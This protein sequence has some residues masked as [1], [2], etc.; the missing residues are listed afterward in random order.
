[1]KSRF[2]S[3]AFWIWLLAA[4]FFFAEYMARVSP[5]VMVPDLMQAF[6]VNALKLGILSSFFYYSYVGM[7]LPVGT[8]IDR[9][10]AHKLVTVMAAL[11]GISCFMFAYSSSI[12][13]AA[14]TR[15]IMGFAAAFAFV[16]A[17]SLARTW[18]KPS[19]F[20]LLAGTTQALGM[21]GAA[22]GEAPV[23]L[24]VS[25]LGYRFALMAIGVGLMVL[26]VLMGIIVRDRPDNA[27][28]VNVDIQEQPKQSLWK[29]LKVV[30]STKQC[31]LN[32]LFVG[33]LYAPTAAFA[34]LWGASYLHTVYVVPEAIAAGMSGVIFIGFAVSSPFAGWISDR[35]KRRKPVLFA[36][37][38]LSFIFLSIVLYLPHLSSWFAAVLLFCYGASN[39]AVATSY[40]VA[41]EFVP[42]NVAAT[43]MSFANMT[44]VIIG[45]LFQP[46]IGKL[47][48]LGWN[49]ITVKGVQVYSVHDYRVAMLS[50]PLC[51]V[52]SIITC[53][54]IKESY[55]YKVV[56]N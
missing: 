29:N 22:L 20:G 54:F 12:Y 32:G 56:E 4:V 23:S 41:S 10:G 27:A 37:A 19:K 25:H 30:L 24:M 31:W 45:A 2:F 18:F 51:L 33:C 44:S 43:S 15:F 42:D 9:Y 38:I 53:F 48:V 17:L 50:L 7:Q 28:V 5:S 52:I 6:N 1:M 16:G 47:L 36:S 39:V 40:T 11:C 13:V 46:I 35:I 26:A 3:K 34:E 49:H 21:L 14:L 55:G 8:L